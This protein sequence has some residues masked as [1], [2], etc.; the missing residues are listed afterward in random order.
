MMIKIFNINYY[1]CH[2]HIVFRADSPIDESVASELD[3]TNIAESDVSYRPSN[4]SI[5]QFNVDKHYDLRF[6]Q[7]QFSCLHLKSVFLFHLNLHLMLSAT[8]SKPQVPHGVK[9]LKEKKLFVIIPFFYTIFIYNYF[10]I[11]TV[12]YYVFMNVL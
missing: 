4:E 3:K 6:V 7:M 10:I 12:F 2:V 1:Q 5:E 11:Y 8:N 9:V